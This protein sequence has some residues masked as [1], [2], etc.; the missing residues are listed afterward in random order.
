[1]LDSLYRALARPLAE[2]MPLTTAQALGMWALLALIGTLALG[3]LW[4]GG[5]LWLATGA[6]VG[7]ATLLVS[8]FWLAAAV[9]VL[10]P[11]LGGASG[12]TH[13]PGALATAF[14]P[15]LLAGPLAALGT[16][17][18]GLA[19][20]GM[21]LVLVWIALALVRQVAIAHALSWGRAAWCLVLALGAGSAAFTLLLLGP[22]VLVAWW[23]LG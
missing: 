2:P 11:P 13:S 21:L 15:F 12:T 8:W 16:R 7:Y 5:T 14:W 17:Y 4:G 3:G 9:G 6:L 20:A 19:T 23:A 1:M 10:A 18:P 22:M